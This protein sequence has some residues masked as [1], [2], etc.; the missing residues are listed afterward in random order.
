MKISQ[1]QGNYR[2]NVLGL[3]LIVFGLFIASCDEVAEILDVEFDINYTSEITVPA[4]TGINLPLD[5]F[6]PEVTTNSEATFGNNNTSKDLIKEI[7]LKSLILTITS[8]SSQRFDFLKEITVYIN[9]EGLGELEIASAKDVADNIGNEL[10][11]VVSDNNLQSYIKKDKFTL[12]V[13]AVTDEF[14]NED[15]KIEAASTYHVVANPL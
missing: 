6:T 10:E 1:I 8:P 14:I 12:R 5:L 15:V 7:T 2:N 11:L 4:S 9:A 3:F 13:N